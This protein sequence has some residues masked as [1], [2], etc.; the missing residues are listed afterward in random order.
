MKWGTNLKHHNLHNNLGWIQKI[1]DTEQTKMPNYLQPPNL[2]QGFSHLSSQPNSS[3]LNLAPI[4]LWTSKYLPSYD[5]NYWSRKAYMV[6]L[7]K[8]ESNVAIICED[9]FL[10]RIGQMY[11][12]RFLWTIFKI[13][14]V[15][16]KTSK[17][18][19][20]FYSD[21]FTKEGIISNKNHWQNN[22][23]RKK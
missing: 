7:S 17:V 8:I 23:S 22:E 4:L 9:F 3:N 10:K 15:C 20:C 2:F 1:N 19:K 21:S 6:P 16:F 11:P 13:M 5:V 18:K 12:I 14:P